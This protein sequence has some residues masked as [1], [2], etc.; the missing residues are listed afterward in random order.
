M[1]PNP[2]S[3]LSILNLRWEIR[4]DGSWVAKLRMDPL[5]RWATRGKLINPATGGP[6]LIWDSI[7]KSN[8]LWGDTQVPSPSHDT[9]YSKA[10][11]P[12]SKKVKCVYCNKLRHDEHKYMKKQLDHLSHL[13]YKKK[14]TQF[15]QR[16]FTSWRVCQGIGEERKRKGSSSGTCSCCISTFLMGA[17]LECFTP[18]GFISRWPCIFGALYYID[19]LDGR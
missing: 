12:K 3:G 1:D 14:I 6:N 9:S 17:W 10:G 13:L 11:K 15:C 16:E 5:F 2:Q 4:E 7:N 8:L 19:Y 18:H